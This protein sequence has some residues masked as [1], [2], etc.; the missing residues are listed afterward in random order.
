MR[1]LTLGDI[2]PDA[3]AAMTRHE[4]TCEPFEDLASEEDDAGALD[5]PRQALRLLTRDQRQL[6]T[7]DN[8]FVHTLYE[9]KLSFAGVIVLILDSAAGDQAAAID[10]LFERYPRLT[11]R[12]LYTITGSRV[13]IRQL[14]GAGQA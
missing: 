9:E 3:L 4:Q 10:R 14:P 2:H 11:P 6:L 12:R 8:G 7:T 13:K 5:S 1:F